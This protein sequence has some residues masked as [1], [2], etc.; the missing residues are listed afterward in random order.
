MNIHERVLSVLACRVCRITTT[1]IDDLC[2]FLFE[3][4]TLMKLLLALRIQSQWI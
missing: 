4:S 3:I 1:T 2:F